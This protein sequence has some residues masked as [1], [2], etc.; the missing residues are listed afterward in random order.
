MVARP[1]I[2]Y[3]YILYSYAIEQFPI[4]MKNQTG[5]LLLGKFVWSVV[6]A[7]PRLLF[8][9]YFEYCTASFFVQSMPIPHI[10]SYCKCVSMHD[11]RPC[12]LH[13]AS[14]GQLQG[15][16][17]QW[18]SEMMQIQRCQDFGF[19]CVEAPLFFWP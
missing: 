9:F 1:F 3:S 11:P 5:H 19:S 12:I 6:L 7:N 18:S 2:T 15:Q 8:L 14:H 4:R 17:P 16:F 13:P 10:T